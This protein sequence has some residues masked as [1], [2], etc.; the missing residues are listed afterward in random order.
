VIS[1]QH[2]AAHIKKSKTATQLT[3]ISAVF[4]LQSCSTVEAGTGRCKAFKD[5]KYVASSNDTDGK[6]WTISVN[7]DT[8]DLKCDFKEGSTPT[9]GLLIFTAVVRDGQGFA[10]PALA[11]NAGFAGATTS[12]GGAGFVVDPDGTNDVATDSC[13]TAVFKVKWT[14]PAPKKSAG[15]YFYVSS[16]PLGSKAV[17]VTLEHTV[18]PDTAPVVV[19]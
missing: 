8:S 6:P 1:T 4:A 18:Q 15:G 14:C 5:P 10:K 9:E 12:Q 19:K 16:G 11:I 17:K 7:P 3:A 13:G 2:I